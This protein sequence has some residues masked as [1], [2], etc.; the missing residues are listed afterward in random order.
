MDAGSGWWW[1]VSVTPSALVV[2]ALF[3]GRE[4][5]RNKIRAEVDASV[6]Q[7]L[8]DHRNEL[9]KDLAK[10]SSQLEAESERLRAKHG[11]ELT[12]FA[13]Y[14]EKRHEAIRALYAEMLL[15]YTE[16]RSAHFLRADRVDGAE[17]LGKA[18]SRAQGAHA[19]HV[20]YLPETVDFAASEFITAIIKLWA[21]VM[22]YVPSE[23]PERWGLWDALDDS[24]KALRSVSRRALRFPDVDMAA[25]TPLAAASATATIPAP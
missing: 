15:A 17:A 4:Y 6:Q 25:L 2:G 20:L 8:D 9:A 23:D 1:L 5:F 18:L 7:R 10:Y 11:R 19:N 22:A 3:F 16:A 14:A 12:D 24:L 13:H 21:D